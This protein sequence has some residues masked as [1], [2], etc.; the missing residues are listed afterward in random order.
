MLKDL[1][2]GQ[3]HSPAADM[4]CL[5]AGAA[6]LANELV[7]SFSEGA[8]LALATLR[9]GKAKRKLEDV[10]EYTQILAG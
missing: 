1:L 6:L 8:R 3:N 9:E 10:I 7:D 4:I 5:N 2:S